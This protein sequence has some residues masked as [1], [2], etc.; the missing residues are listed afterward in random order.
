MRDL[1]L[2]PDDPGTVCKTEE[3]AEWWVRV[4]T[5]L[6]AELANEGTQS[7]SVQN[8]KWHRL[9]TFDLICGMD[10]QIRAS[11]GQ[12]MHMCLQCLGIGACFVS[13]RRE[14]QCGMVCMTELVFNG[15]LSCARA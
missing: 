3:I 15:V 14:G 7:S 5:F 11:L 12:A 9:A 6:A 8:A 4:E 10:W 2:R 1:R 13:V